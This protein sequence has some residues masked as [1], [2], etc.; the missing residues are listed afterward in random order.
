M[1][2]LRQRLLAAFEREK[3]DH[4][5]SMRELLARP[6][7]DREELVRRAHTLK[8]AAAAVGWPA[9]ARL[10]GCLE[11]AFLPAEADLTVPLLQHTLDQL[12][13]TD[14]D[15][16]EV[17]ECW[18]SPAAACN[19]LPTELRW[20]VRAG[21]QVY[22]LPGSQVEQ[23]LQVTTSSLRIWRGW[24]RLLHEGRRITAL[25]LTQLL[26]LPASTV[27][28]ARWPALLLRYRGRRLL[29]LLEEPP[30]RLRGPASVARLSSA[31]LLKA[32]RSGH[33][34]PL[35]LQA[36]AGER[37]LVV[38]DSLTTRSLQREILEAHGYRVL[39]AEDGLEALQ[40]LAS[41][42]VNLILTDLQM[43]RLDGFGLVERLQ[44]DPALATIPVVLV[45]SLERPANL[46]ADAYLNKRTFTQVQLLH[47]VACVLTA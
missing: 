25:P 36:H 44:A 2:D 28:R 9:G 7:P 39:I 15:L 33:V 6:Q 17:L 31:R 4:I 16:T 21:A 43:P 40:I 20:E 18:R 37:I 11:S 34:L 26:D 32:Y 24:P 45:S 5:L 1:D 46:S 12:E 10:A 8:G 13:K 3:A 35:A 47:T 23:I 30:R 22:W 42:P 19:S 38:D 27:P 14:S 41:E 29:L